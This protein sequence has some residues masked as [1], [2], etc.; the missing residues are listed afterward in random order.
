MARVLRSHWILSD[1]DT[2]RLLRF[3]A[4]LA[5]LALAFTTPAPAPADHS[6]A[7]TESVAVSGS[8][9]VREAAPVTPSE[10]LALPAEVRAATAPASS[11][12]TPAL[13]L[14]S[15]VILLTGAAQ[16]VRGKRGP[17]TA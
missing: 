9:A 10:T 4:G 8:V 6:V 3:L 11:E 5:L 14:G 13:A 15:L 12:I 2:R 7:L 1:W 16:R 17:P